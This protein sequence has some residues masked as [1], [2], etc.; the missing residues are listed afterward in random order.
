MT[1]KNHEKRR[2][3]GG[4]T[5]SKTRHM[6]V[7]MKWVLW[8]VAV[9]LV[10]LTVVAVLVHARSLSAQLTPEE[11]IARDGKAYGVAYP[12][13]LTDVLGGQNFVEYS[14]TL[15]NRSVGWLMVGHVP[16]AKSGVR[17]ATVGIRL[18][19][20]MNVAWISVL[21][22]GNEYADLAAAT[23]KWHDVKY[24]KAWQAGDDMLFGSGSTVARDLRTTVQHSIASLYAFNYGDDAYHAMAILVGAE[25][26]KNGD[27][28]PSFAAVSTS[29][30]PIS[31]G[32]LHGQKVVLIATSPVC[33]SCFDATVGILKELSAM[34]LKET[35]SVVLVLAPADNARSIA[36]KAAV[37]P[38]VL[39]V[40]DADEHL[41]RSL[42]M[43]N[44]PYV[45][46]V[47]RDGTVLFHGS[48]YDRASVTAALKELAALP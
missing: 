48:G 18:D 26:F 22:G 12:K 32:T 14:V 36:L 20:G 7:A 29:G 43:Q 5:T 35:R 17:S 21:S 41:A 38:G 4:G 3:V 42:F 27:A 9:A 8:L 46:L 47:G 44:S 10:A 40:Q 19:G 33:G 13:T 39:L 16:V 24:T 28:L 25:G 37:P 23:E 45:V 11:A 6:S 31:N 15:G 1:K 30:T 2:S 34:N